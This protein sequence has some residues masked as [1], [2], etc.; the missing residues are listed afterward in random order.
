PRETDT[1]GT[2]GCDCPDG[3]GPSSRS[4]V[5]KLLTSF[6][7]RPSANATAHTRGI[8]SARRWIS[9]QK[10]PTRASGYCD[11]GSSIDPLKT[12]RALKP[13]LTRP[14]SLRLT[15]NRPATTTSGVAIANWLPTR[16]R[17][18]RL[19]ST[20]PV[21]DR[22]VERS[23]SSTGPPLPWTAGTR[24]KRIALPAVNPASSHSTGPSS[25]ISAVR[26]KY[27]APKSRSSPVASHVR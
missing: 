26:G 14:S 11:I 23:D 20:V 2:T 16:T 10:A 17:R 6:G 9:S 7:G 8:D 4:K 15:S 13:R 1:H 24:P 21:D 3:V 27:A 19:T 12:L 5:L 25:A 18:N 22:P